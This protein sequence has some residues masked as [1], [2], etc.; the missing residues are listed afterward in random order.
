MVWWLD[1]YPQLAANA[2]ALGMKECIQHPGQTLWTPPN[3]F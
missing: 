1:V 2:A 3:W